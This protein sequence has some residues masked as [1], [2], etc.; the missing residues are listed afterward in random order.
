MNAELTLIQEA[1]YTDPYDQSIWFYHSFLTTAFS[2]SAAL[3]AASVAPGLTGAERAGYLDAQVDMV[4]EM[5]EGA[6]DCKWIFQALVEMATT[7]RRDAGR[8]PEGITVED[9]WGWMDEL[10]K[11]D[12]LRKGRWRDVRAGVEELMAGSDSI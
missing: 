8:W 3:S 5:L 11:L 10:E 1:L 7:Q 6:E 12:P 9:I 2:A 4:H